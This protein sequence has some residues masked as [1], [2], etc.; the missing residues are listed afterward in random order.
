MRSVNAA[1]A[2]KGETVNDVPTQD[3]IY[4]AFNEG[5]EAHGVS[6]V[7]HFTGKEHRCAYKHGEHHPDLIRAWLQGFEAARQRAAS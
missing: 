7:T 6:P 1:T 2:A 3:Q 4:A 5:R